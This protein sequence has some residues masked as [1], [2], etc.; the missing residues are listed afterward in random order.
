MFNPFSVKNFFTNQGK[1]ILFSQ[2]VKDFYME[3]PIASASI[4]MAECSLFMKQDTNKT[5]FFNEKF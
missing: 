2:P 4:T 5:N 3:N 1:L